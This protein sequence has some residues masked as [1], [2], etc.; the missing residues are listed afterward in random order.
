[1]E[2]SLY[3]IE[4]L[5]EMT[6]FSRRTIRYYIQIGLIDPPAG[7][8]RGGFYND[9]HMDALRTV[10]TLQEKGMNL[11]AIISYLRK[12]VAAGQETARAVWVRYD[13]SPGIEL[14]VRRDVEEKQGKMV[15]R[16]MRVIRSITE[17]EAHG[18]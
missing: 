17:E 2:Q 14:S 12:G 1:M 10:R 7:R 5:T 13:I 3:T 4:Q 15:M 16:L 6:G 11:S 18:E 8:G 9:S